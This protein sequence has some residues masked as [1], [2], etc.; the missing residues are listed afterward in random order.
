MT[1]APAPTAATAA[2]ADRARATMEGY[3]QALVHRGPFADYS[4][5]DVAFSVEG[6][7]QTA[8]GAVAVE[9]M[10][11]YLH[12][13]AFDAHPELTNLLVDGHKAAIEA[14]FVG[15]HTAEFAGIAATG[16]RVRVPYSV[17]YDLHSGRI[18]ALRVY[19][20][21]NALVEQLGAAA[22]APQT[23]AAAAR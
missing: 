4:D 16:R 14:D 2:S 23:A 22:P 19:L 6:S 5:A 11:R 10:I 12:Q 13:I 15:T 18:A 3:L 20:P 8:R 17:L 1:N 7:G 9:H 21:M